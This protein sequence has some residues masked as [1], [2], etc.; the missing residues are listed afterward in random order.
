MLMKEAGLEDVVSGI[1]LSSFGLTAAE[2]LI[3]CLED[4]GPLAGR[5]GTYALGALLRQLLTPELEWADASFI[6]YLIVEHRLVG[7]DYY[8]SKLRAEY[9]GTP[10]TLSG[11]KGI[12]LRPRAVADG[13]EAKGPAPRYTNV[14]LVDDTTSERCDDARS[15]APDTEYHLRI[16][17]G[18][19]RDTSVVKNV[20]AARV[21]TELLPESER[22]D[23]GYWLDVIVTSEDF[24]V[25]H[26][27]DALFLP[28]EGDSWVCD[29][30]RGDDVE[31]RCDKKERAP[32]LYVPVTSPAVTGEATLRIGFYF[33]NNLLQCHLFTAQIGT[34]VPDGKDGYD[35]VVDY[36]L[37]H[38]LRDVKDRFPARTLNI[39]T[40]ENADGSHR[41]VTVGTED[42]EQEG[43]VRHRP[44]SAGT[45]KSILDEA[46]ATLL[47]TLLEIKRESI[48]EVRPDFTESVRRGDW[49]VK[50]KT[51][52][53][54]DGTQ[55]S[56]AKSKSEFIADL[57]RL[58]WWG[59]QLWT[60]LFPS[61]SWDEYNRL[62][63]EHAIIQTCRAENSASPLLFPWALIYDIALD[64]AGRDDPHRWKNCPSLEDGNWEPGKPLI[65]LQNSRCPYDDGENHLLDVIC[66]YGFWG[67]KHIIE[68]PPSMPKGVEMPLKIALS[69][70]Y[71]EM[72][73]GFS[74]R[75]PNP[76]QRI[77]HLEKKL[78]G[79]L[80]VKAIGIDSESDNSRDRILKEL[81]SAGL[82][83]VYLYCHGL[84]R[85]LPESQQPSET[86]G[87][88]LELALIEVG[89]ENE[90]ITSSDITTYQ[91]VGR[92]HWTDTRPLVFINGCHTVELSPDALIGF[93]DTFIQAEAGGVVGTEVTVT[94]DLADEVAE[95][96]L[97]Y[98]LEENATVGQAIRRMRCDLLAK[99]NLMGLAYTPYCSAD[100]Q[101]E[102]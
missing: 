88:K 29:C 101:L 75:L 25:K 22:G 3:A 59:S 96:F 39:F 95:L 20:E 51:L 85:K 15:L 94:P 52:T 49:D 82:E 4:H 77:R 66:P 37:T 46:R 73:V 5:L 79:K 69:D 12:I 31:H 17:I 42:E 98:L 47:R 50:L 13:S 84:W 81:G 40:N 34:R 44:L 19:W 23:E 71:P 93:V 55:I 26:E 6:A 28:K 56:N 45:V 100:L 18:E 8:L 89:K 90:R 57:R 65:D 97:S 64:S 58:A 35:S 24:E 7:D 70:G 54:Q 11:D 30:P 87:G 63:K 60:E 9:I 43:F 48:V 62:L 80:Q 36:T 76:R 53:M 1:D 99:G 91:R 16:D 10:A 86:A 68:Q 32:Y 14:D 33:K 21:R 61:D 27:H 41:V 92:I 83:F 38:S 74:E 102:G 72:L 67:I 2:E 78:L